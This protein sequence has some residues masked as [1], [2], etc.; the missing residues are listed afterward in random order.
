MDA[1]TLKKAKQ[2]MTMC[3]ACPVCN[4]LGCRGRMPGPGG[5][6]NNSSF[7]HSV[8]K[9]GQIKIHMDTIC[10]VFVP[11][12]G[13]D[14]FGKSFRYPIFA[15]PIGMLAA[16][17][18][19]HYNDGSYTEELLA[20]SEA[21]GVGVFT[22]DGP[23]PGTFEQPLAL[24]K[25]R[26]GNGIPTVKTWPDE[27]MK[28]RLDMVRDAGA[29]AVAT[30]VDCLGLIQ[31]ESP[32]VAKTTEE[33]RALA[34]YAGRPF[35]IK[36]VMTAAGAQKAVQAGAAGIVVSTHGGRVMADAPAPI[37]VLPE[38][39]KAVNKQL[40]IFVDGGI[41]TGADIFKALALGA[42]AVLVGRP[43]VV[44]A[45]GA[46][47]EGVRQYAQQLGEELRQ[48]MLLAG[49]TKLAQIGPEHVFFS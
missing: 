20:G 46:G 5:R 25:S 26:G 28:Q 16:N 14:V 38:I 21:A 32:F 23:A 37:E 13:F 7:I 31:G 15:A 10:G 17:F 33:L 19:P 9:L 8:Q 48:T 4:G 24:I 29:F 18:G 35:I 12:T 39:A 45:Y 30:D 2:N 41:R 40:T 42:D 1:E 43:F 36:G 22:G 27:K 6:G 44:A 3:E 47:A 11:D 34:A 49:V